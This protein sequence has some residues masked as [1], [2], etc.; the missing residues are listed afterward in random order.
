MTR[1]GRVFPCLAERLLSKLDLRN[2]NECWI[3]QGAMMGDYGCLRRNKT[4]GGDVIQAHV[5]AYELRNGK[6]PKGLEVMHDC[7]TPRCCNPDHLKIGTHYENMQEMV[8]RKRYC[9]R[10]GVLHGR[11]TKLNDDKVRNIRKLY[12]TGEYTLTKL[13]KEYGVDIALISSVVK[14]QAWKHVT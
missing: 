12:A 14:R 1:K 7:D 5:A 4:D 2:E 11:G 3:W 6:V 9:A 10:P 13:A 8:K